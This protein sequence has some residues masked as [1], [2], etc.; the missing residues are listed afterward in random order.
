MTCNPKVNTALICIGKGAEAA[1]YAPSRSLFLYP[2]TEHTLAVEPVIVGY[3][4]DVL[5]LRS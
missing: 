5:D 3:Q 4:R 1:R 2:S